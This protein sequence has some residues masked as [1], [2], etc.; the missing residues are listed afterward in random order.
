[1]RRK[2]REGNLK[3]RLAIRTLNVER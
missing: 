3:F 1:Q 2:E